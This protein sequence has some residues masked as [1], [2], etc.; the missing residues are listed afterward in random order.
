MR[1][2]IIKEG[3]DK[4]GNIRK[5]QAD[6][7]AT[8]DLI[9]LAEW[10]RSKRLSRRNKCARGAMRVAW[11]AAGA[12]KC[13]AGTARCWFRCRLCARRAPFV[14]QISS[15]WGGVLALG[16]VA[17]RR[18]IGIRDIYRERRLLWMWR[19][20]IQPDKNIV[21]DAEPRRYMRRRKMSKV[22]YLRARAHWIK[23]QCKSV[24]E[25]GQ[26]ARTSAPVTPPPPTLDKNGAK[27][28][29]G[30]SFIVTGQ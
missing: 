13:R 7:L 24:G 16:N 26:V 11:A 14:M 20:C 25:T 22:I 1:L 19:R 30:V 3:R 5:A 29:G 27:T 10:A 9:R 28:T 17:V 21:P 6:A 2:F 18:T 4:K 23:H 8:L 15:L 12:C